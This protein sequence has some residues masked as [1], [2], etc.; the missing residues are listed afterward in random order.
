M[1][2]ILYFSFLEFDL[3]LIQF[4]YRSSSS[5]QHRKKRSSPL[6]F[7]DLKQKSIKITSNKERQKCKSTFVFRKMSTENHLT[8]AK[9]KT[10]W[11]SSGN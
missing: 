3:N 9:S 2:F 11:N 7:I 1:K 8:V 10:D 5:D 4:V 6:I